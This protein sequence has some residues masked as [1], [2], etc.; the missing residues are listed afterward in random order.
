MDIADAQFIRTIKMNFSFNQTLPWMNQKAEIMLCDTHLDSSRKK[1]ALTNQSITKNINPREF[2]WHRKIGFDCF[3]LDQSV[4]SPLNVFHKSWVLFYSA[5]LKEWFLPFVRGRNNWCE[6]VSW[7]WL[8]H[9]FTAEG[10]NSPKGYQR[11]IPKLS[12]FDWELSS[13]K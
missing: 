2:G 13:S 9:N 7:A 4:E 3:C 6:T 1:C 12:K 5:V 8:A 11:N 10:R